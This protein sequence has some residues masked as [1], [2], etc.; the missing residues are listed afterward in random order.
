MGS[1]TGPII[2][3]QYLSTEQLPHCN[4]DRKAIFDIYCENEQGEKFIV[5][6]KKPNKTTLKTAV[7]TI[8]PFLSS[9]KP[10]KVIELQT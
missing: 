5:E 3:L 7:F 8:P 9:N 10:K 2:A 6:C 4:D 1:E